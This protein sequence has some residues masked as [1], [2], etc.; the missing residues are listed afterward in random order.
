LAPDKLL[1]S[2]PNEDNHP[3]LKPAKPFTSNLP[4]LS[5]ATVGNA[6]VLAND[7]AKHS[8]V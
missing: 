7:T 2:R 3:M 6:P 1:E 8:I 4:F 5:L